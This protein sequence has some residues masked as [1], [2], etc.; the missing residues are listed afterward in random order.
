VCSA[1]ATTLGLVCPGGTRGFISY[2]TGDSIRHI[3]WN[4]NFNPT[5]P[6]YGPGGTL[7]LA[8]SWNDL[9]RANYDILTTFNGVGLG[10]TNVYTDSNADGTFSYQ[11]CKNGDANGRISDNQWG[12]A[13]RA[14]CG[15]IP[16]ACSTSRPIMCVCN[17]GAYYVNSGSPIPTFTA[18]TLWGTGRTGDATYFGGSGSR[19]TSTAI[20]SNFLTTAGYSCTATPMLLSYSGGDD[21]ASFAATYSFSA[22]TAVKGP[23]G[24]TIQ[25]S[26][27][28]FL[29]AG[30]TGASTIRNADCDGYQ[31][32]TG[33]TSTGA[34]S[35]STCSDWTVTTGSAT[36]GGAESTSSTNMK[37]QTTLA[38]SSTF[39]QG[40]CLCVN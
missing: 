37:A 1:R 18:L 29:A 34:T 7:Q 30:V 20:C 2:A 27:T 4:L 8:N 10:T 24:T 32:Y 19:A 25:S 28:N 16:A 36:A 17:R 39:A 31:F 5:T 22:A 14:K 12:N 38:C 13:G 33:T 3:P 15:N 21:L 11:S 23:S 40:I 26:W 35:A 9:M 6:V